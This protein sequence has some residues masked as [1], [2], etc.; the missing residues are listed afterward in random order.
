MRALIAVAA[1]L[2][3]AACATPVQEQGARANPRP[4]GQF[5]ATTTEK[6]F[7]WPELRSGD[8]VMRPGATLILRPDGT[9]RFNGTV[10][11]TDQDERWRI[12]FE[13]FASNNWKLFTLPVERG[14]GSGYT[15]AMPQARAD[16]GWEINPGNFD[17]SKFEHVDIV[18]MFY[19]C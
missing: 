4:L 18:R 11:S 2:L 8:C 3:L 6:T 1:L 9:S 19:R 5:P 15:K 7:T 16:Y 17:P 10:W 14:E 13:V 12:W